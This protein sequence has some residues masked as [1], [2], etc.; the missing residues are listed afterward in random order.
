MSYCRGIFR[1]LA[2]AV[3]LFCL[4]VIGAGN[5]LAAEKSSDEKD[6]LGAVYQNMMEIKSLHYEAQMDASLPIGKL[7]GVMI[8]DA[9][10]NPLCYQHDLNLL[11]CDEKKV[12]HKF[13]AK[14]YIEE[15]EGVLTS[16]LQSNDKWIKQ[17]MPLTKAMH[18]KMS[19]QEQETALKS[20]LG[21][22]K[23]VSLSRET[24]SYKYMEITLDA[25]KI[26]DAVEAAV[27]QENKKQPAEVERGFAIGRLALLAAG[28]IKYQVKIDK[29]SQMITEVNMDLTEP[30]RKGADLFVAA[31]APKDRQQMQTFLAQSTLT[32]Q[33]KYSN[34][35][36]VANIV[37]PQ[38]VK[39]QAVEAKSSGLPSTDALTPAEA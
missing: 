37:I 34:Y 29:G 35:N 30:I 18:Q 39:D 12:E 33:V 28:D 3:V 16:Y 9:Q 19:R 4:L 2:V 21:M 10:E 11:Y 1:K 31:G 27:K 15:D 22:I 8:G 17:T 25:V 23:N 26:S 20:M 32:L 13:S 5:A 7:Q 24:P 38:Q 36:A 6:Y 14:Q